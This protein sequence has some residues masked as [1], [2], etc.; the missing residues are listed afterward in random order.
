MSIFRLFERFFDRNRHSEEEDRYRHLIRTSPAPINLF[1]AEGR[2]IWGNDAV[3]DLLGLTSREDLIER[4]IFE[5]IHPEYHEIAEREVET[6]IEDKQATGPTAMKLTREDGDIRHVRVSTAPGRLDGQDIGQ[7]VVIDTTSVIEIQDTLRD[8]R[9]FIEGILD[10][11]PDLYYLI[12]QDGAIN[13]WNSVATEVTGYTDEE[14][15]ELDIHD[16]FSPADQERIRQ[17]VAT[18]ITEGQDRLEAT[19][20]TKDGREIPYE[21]HGRALRDENG[22]IIGITGIGRD[23]SDRQERDQHLKVVDRLLRHNL[24]NKLNV[25]NGYAEIVQSTGSQEMRSE[26][27]QIISASKAL[28]AI[29][30]KER[31]IVDVLVGRPTVKSID[32]DGMIEDVVASV[33]V[34]YPVASFEYDI[35]STVSVRAIDSLDKALFELLENA[36]VH[37][38][39]DV[40][41]IEIGA[42]D[43]GEKVRLTISDNAPLIPRTER[44]IVGKELEDQP[45]HHSQGLGLWFVFWVINRS[46]G[47]LTFSEN[48]R[49][50]NEIVIELDRG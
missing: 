45:L 22:D 34:E 3:L 19:L 47:T 42:V 35:P 14:I 8:E 1:D 28:L 24:R 6:V 30:K 11:F 20:Q 29:A 16:L 10:T 43:H 5:F 31:E 38:D 44:E 15:K 2:T 50:G 32:L 36:V 40:P 23:V 48:D 26:L 37:N 49:G 17:S 4:S 25:I 41:M 21:F 9:R 27:D 33:S 13:D 18:V 7:A 12:D 39:S 46:N